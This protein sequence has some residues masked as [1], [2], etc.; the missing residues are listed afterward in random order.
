MESKQLIIRFL[1]IMMFCLIIRLIYSSK[2][3]T[4]A[5]WIWLVFGLGFL[6]LMFW[7]GAIDLSMKLLGIDSWME[8][9]Y[10]FILVSLLVINIHFAMVISGLTDISKNLA[11]EIT[12]LNRE[13]ENNRKD[14]NT[15]ITSD[16]L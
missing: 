12:F 11:Q 6:V 16:I 2:L 13:I 3:K 4:G 10:L 9:V 5:S 7:P 1:S 14:I 8:I 15:Q